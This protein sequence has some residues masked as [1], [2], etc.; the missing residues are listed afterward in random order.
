MREQSVSVRICSEVEELRGLVPG[1]S[2]TILPLGDGPFHAEVVSC[3]LGDISLRIGHSTAFLAS[4][5]I[6]PDRVQ[7]LLPFTGQGRIIFHDRRFERHDVAVAPSGCLL[8]GASHGEAEW[9]VVMMPAGTARRL[10]FPRRRSWALC[11]GQHCLLRPD[12]AAWT[13]AASLLRSVREVFL[14]DPAIFDAPEP[15][16][17]LRDS[18]LQAMRELLAGPL[19]AIP[20][21]GVLRGGGRRRC[22]IDRSGTCI[23]AHLRPSFPLGSAE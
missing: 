22:D 6:A 23:A 14:G 12:P 11:A 1:A 7:L 18:L 10:I 2:F 9:A 5:S 16:R 4:G 19:V 17:A 8:D 21:G 20:A 3:E 15:R 13:G